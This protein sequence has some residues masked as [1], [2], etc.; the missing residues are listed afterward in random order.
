MDTNRSRLIDSKRDA[1]KGSGAD[2][3]KPEIRSILR[4]RGCPNEVR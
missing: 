4:K 2:Q 1:G 3:L